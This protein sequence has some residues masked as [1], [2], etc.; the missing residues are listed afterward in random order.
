MKITGIVMTIIFFAA[1]KNNNNDNNGMTMNATDQQF[2]QQVSVAFGV[3]DLPVRIRRPR[4]FEVIGQGKD[5]LPIPDRMSD[6]SGIGLRALEFAARSGELEP[7]C[8]PVDLYIVPGYR[9]RV[10]D[11]LLTNFHM[12]RTTVLLLVAAFAGRDRI[13]TAYWE[14]IAERYRFLSFGD[15]MLIL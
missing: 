9:F 3:H 11:I 4:D 14:A 10:I 12:P 7:Y 13:L 1:C 2:L 6:G 8:G 5:V 15:A